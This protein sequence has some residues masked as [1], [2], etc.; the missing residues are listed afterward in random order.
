M[1]KGFDYIGLTVS[2]YCH[3]GRGNYVVHKRSEKCRDE[4]GAWDFGGGGIKFGETAEQALLREVNEE[5]GVEPVEYEFLGF[6]DN[7]REIEGRKSHW[8]GFRYKVQLDREKVIN[9]EP[10]K[11]SDLKWVTLDNLPAPLH[12]LIPNELEEYKDKLQ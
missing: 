6:G 7:F 5:Y 3:D 4:C 9:G 10:E 1:E 11:H 2:F 8:V 12:S